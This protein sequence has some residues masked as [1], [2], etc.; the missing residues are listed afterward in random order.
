MKRRTLIRKVL[1]VQTNHVWQL[2]P[3]FLNRGRNLDER[4]VFRIV[5]SARWNRCMSVLLGR[6]AVDLKHDCAQHCGKAAQCSKT[7]DHVALLR[8]IWSPDT[9]IVLASRTVKWLPGIILGEIVHFE[10]LAER[11]RIDQIDSLLKIIVISL[12][13]CL[14]KIGTSFSIGG[15]KAG[16]RPK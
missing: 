8:R 5:F 6:G 2:K 9:S 13:I 14:L 1:D 16:I 7:R 10:R 3:P 15:V 4:N 11:R 12:K